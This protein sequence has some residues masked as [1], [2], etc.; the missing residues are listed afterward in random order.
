[1]PSFSA[2]VSDFDGSK[3]TDKLSGIS[4]RYDSPSGR[5]YFRNET[6]QN[7][8]N[9][10]FNISGTPTEDAKEQLKAFVEA[11][12][13]AYPF[14][15][16]VVDSEEIKQELIKFYQEKTKDPKQKQASIGKFA[17]REISVKSSSASSS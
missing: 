11:V 2:N 17:L 6:G 14:S 10:T 16:I 7:Q 4:E 12:N 8:Q 1:G 9:V 15:K 5:I 3:Y 13:N